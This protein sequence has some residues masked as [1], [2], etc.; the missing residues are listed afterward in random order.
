MSRYTTLVRLLSPLLVGAT[1]ACALPANAADA[2]VAEPVGSVANHT[3]WDLTDLYA[4]PQAWDESYARA[5]AAAEKLG[6][7]KGTLGKSAQDLARALVA[8]SDLNREV[9]RLATYASLDSDQDLRNG[10]NLER[11]QQAQAL[12]TKLS[13][14]SAWVAPEILGV[15]EKKIR[16]FIA[17]DKTLQ[18]RFNY[19]LDNTLRSAPHT[20]GVEA[21]GVLASAGSILAQPDTLHS[22]LANAELPLPT[23]TLSDGTQVKLGQAK[24]EK[25]RQ[26]PV[27]ADRKLVFDEYWGAW[28]KFEGTAGSML[29]TQV[30]GDHFTA[31]A[32]KFDTALQAAQFPDN[33]P[34]KVY[35][36]LVAETNAALPTLHRYLK[37]R[38]RLLGITDDLHYYDNYPPMFKLDVQPKFDVPESERITL[39]ALKPLGEDYLSLMR[40][41]FNS[42]WMSVYPSEGK[43][44]GAYMNG[45]A[46][47]VHP[48]L[49]LNHNGDYQSLSTLAHEWGHAVHTMLTARTQPYEK[50]SYSTF[51]AESASIGNEMLLN[52]YMVAHAK[53]RQ[54]KLYYLGQGLES[55]R[56]TFFRQVQFAEFELAIHE[57]LEKGEP[58]SGERMSQMYCSVLRKYYGEAEGVMKIDPEYCIEWAVVPHFYYNFYVYQYATSMAGAAEL[59]DQILKEGAPARDR[60]VKLLSSGGS[61]YPYEL[62]KRAGIDMATPAPYRAL[63]ARM[64]RLMDDIEKLEAQK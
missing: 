21:E 31:Q 3:M 50:S 22:I 36:T 26:S 55:I 2:P 61:D 59:T 60:F 53:D 40:R 37:M 11:N 16:A 30:M 42:N 43:K 10:A 25:Y 19:Y 32:R 6:D 9:T 34:D 49:L 18:T 13:E 8:I 52:D 7:F 47:D 12:F 39:E 62:Y 46:Y 35:R 45:S 44:L 23:V 63:A 41:G 51:I 27:R 24:Y 38:K 14:S 64:N 15:G 17:E 48:Y 28:K 1:F 54:E 5:K 4:T 56:Q 33:M 58:L 20:L 57:A 29:A